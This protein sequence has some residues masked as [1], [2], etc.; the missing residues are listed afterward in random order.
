MHKTIN[1]QNSPLTQARPVE[2]DLLTLRDTSLQLSQ[3]PIDAGD[4]SKIRIGVTSAIATYTDQKDQL[5]TDEALKVPPGRHRRHSL[6]LALQ[7][8]KATEVLIDMQ[9]DTA[10]ISQSGN[11]RPII[12]A[13]VTPI[14]PTPTPSPSP[15][16]TPP[17]TS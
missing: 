7:A 12:K 5:H 13:S 9:P 6:A 17:P 14:I 11:F 16:P 4:Y 3:N 8:A 10:A 15:S 2:F 1:G